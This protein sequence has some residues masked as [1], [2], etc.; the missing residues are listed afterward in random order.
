MRRSGARAFGCP[1][2]SDHDRVLPKVWRHKEEKPNILQSEVFRWVAVLGSLACLLCGPAAGAPA[3]M[4]TC[5]SARV[6]L[7]T[8]DKHVASS[9]REYSSCVLNRSTREDACARQFS[10]LAADQRYLQIA[11]S[12]QQRLC[13]Q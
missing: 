1:D 6:A 8:I 9:L 2:T 13:W 7:E 12:N 11:V 3:V 5:D 10:A 4:L